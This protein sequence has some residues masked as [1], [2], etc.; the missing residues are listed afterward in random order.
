MAD[1]VLSAAKQDSTDCVQH[2][3]CVVI[4]G[5]IAGVTCAETVIHFSVCY[6]I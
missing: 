3:S 4:G 2:F 6:C 5:G 1:E